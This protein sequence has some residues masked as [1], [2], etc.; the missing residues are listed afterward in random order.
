[1]DFKINDKV[2]YVGTV[3]IM[4]NKTGK[5]I[6]ILKQDNNSQYLVEF[7]S[8]INGHNGAG[9]GKNYHCWY[10][11]EEEINKIG[12][13]KR[14]RNIEL[15]PFD[16]EDWGYIQESLEEKES[17]KFKMGDIITYNSQT[18]GE[19]HGKIVN[20][21]HFKGI[22]TYLVEFG[23]G[24]NSHWH[25]LHNEDLIKYGM[26]RV[27]I[28]KPESDPFDEEDWGY[29][30]ENKNVKNYS[31]FLL[32]YEG[33]PP[34]KDQIKVSSGMMMEIDLDEEKTKKKKKKKEYLNVLSPNITLEN[35]KK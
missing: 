31:N 24:K 10:C 20:I 9:L 32:E 22:H 16:E 28:R 29:I 11:K 7:D 3:P 6:D 27:K 13:G 35:L 14:I 4:L 34:A 17:P 30:Q 8:F 5:I 26:K 33:G 12:G 21:S 23:H 2:L 1:M 18:H 19:E 25:Y 15:D